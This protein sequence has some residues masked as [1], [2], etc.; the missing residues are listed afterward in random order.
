MNMAEVTGMEGDT[1]CLQ[2]VFRFRQSG[3]DAQGYATG[4]F[5]AC[6]VKPKLYD[7]IASEGVTLPLDLF[8]QRILQTV[9][10]SR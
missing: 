10:A 6:G 4:T 2:D 9:P 1:L 3:I 5:E 7:R 8:R